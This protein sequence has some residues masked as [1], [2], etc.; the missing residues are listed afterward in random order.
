MVAQPL[1]TTIEVTKAAVAGSS[2]WQRMHRN[3][4]LDEK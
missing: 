1:T 2:C 3:N 4:I